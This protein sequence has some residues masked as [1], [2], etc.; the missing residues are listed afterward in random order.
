MKSTML[1]ALPLDYVPSYEDLQT[2]KGIGPKVAD[3]IL[4]YSFHNLER[5]PM[6]VWMNRFQN[7]LYN[8]KLSWENFSPY[9]GICQ[10]Y[11]YYHYR[12]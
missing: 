5:V 8:G 7:Q 2:V 3:C 4:L 9:Q 11:L 10:Q 1:S 6:D 12:K